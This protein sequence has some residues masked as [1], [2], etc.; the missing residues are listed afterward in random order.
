MYP[1]EKKAAEFI[2]HDDEKVL[3]AERRTPRWDARKTGVAGLLVIIAGGLVAAFA[4]GIINGLALYVLLCAVMV[5]AIQPRFSWLRERHTVYLLTDKRAIIV[6]EALWGCRAAA[7]AVPLHREL[8][9]ACKRRPNGRADYYFVKY[10]KGL[11][12]PKDGFLNVQTTQQLE[13]QLAEL[14][15]TLPDNDAA[16]PLTQ[17]TRPTPLEALG[18]YLLAGCYLYDLVGKKWVERNLAWWAYVLLGLCVL[19]LLQL[20]LRELRGF[21]R[22]RQQSFYIFTPEPRD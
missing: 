16:R 6:E 17:V 10:T 3:W 2:L 4:A 22:M 13:A 14:G 21:I 12:L 5:L 8:I 19:K 15:L 1:K 9:A 20:I 11:N 7:V 18:Y